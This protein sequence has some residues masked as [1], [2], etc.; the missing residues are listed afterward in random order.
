MRF[1][2]RE[3]QI[4]V[5]AIKFTGENLTELVEFV[6][7]PLKTS[8]ET[9]LIPSLGTEFPAEKNDWVVLGNRGLFYVIKSAEFK[10]DF[11]PVVE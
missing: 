9:V 10:A 5:T 11:E 1:K 7:K 4:E 3:T 8:G 2:N 6:E